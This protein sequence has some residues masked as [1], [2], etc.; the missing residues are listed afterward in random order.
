[1][2]WRVVFTGGTGDVSW[3]LDFEVPPT[4]DVFCVPGWDTYDPSHCGGVDE[5]SITL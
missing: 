2:T 1:M 5:L 3:S 4:G